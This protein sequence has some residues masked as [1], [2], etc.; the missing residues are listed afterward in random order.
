M[1]FCETVM[2]GVFRICQFRMAKKSILAQKGF[3]MG[4]T[5]DNKPSYMPVYITNVFFL[6]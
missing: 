6:D 2:K 4:D 5:H 3:N 1:A